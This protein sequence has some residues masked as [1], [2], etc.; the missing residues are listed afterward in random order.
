MTVRIQAIGALLIALVIPV[1]VLAQVRVV[2]ERP[3]C[4]HASAVARF[5]AMA[6]DHWVHVESTCSVTV[7][8]TVS[9]DVNPVATSLE[10]TPGQQR[11]VATFHGSPASAFVATVACE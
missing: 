1:L 4:V 10:L 8:C 11:D 6:Y 5:G 9:T 7:H 2:G 3:D